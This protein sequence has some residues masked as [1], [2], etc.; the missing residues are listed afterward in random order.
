LTRHDKDF[1]T[2]E[3]VDKSEM[4]VRYAGMTDI[5]NFLHKL[6]TVLIP[7]ED[8]EA[9]ARD[10]VPVSVFGGCRY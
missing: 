5:M 4:V 8:R 6:E 3:H 10:Y 9:A 2:I 7:I 1:L